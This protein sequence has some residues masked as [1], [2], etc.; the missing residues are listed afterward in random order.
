MKKIEPGEYI[1]PKNCCVKVENHGTT[2]RIV[3]RVHKFLEK[4]EYRCLHCSHRVRGL[5]MSDHGFARPGWVCNAKKKPMTKNI[6]RY[7]KENPKSDVVFYYASNPY[8]KPCEEFSIKNPE[9]LNHEKD[10]KYEK[11][12]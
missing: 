9:F 12:A 4:T 7:F 1:L 11:K 3:Q 8:S 5:I 6:R 10:K 2:I